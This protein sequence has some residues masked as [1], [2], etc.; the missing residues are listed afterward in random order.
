MKFRILIQLI[1]VLLTILSLSVLFPLFGWIL[2]VANNPEK[3]L[4]FMKQ[5]GITFSMII[6][7]ICSYGGIFLPEI[8][9]EIKKTK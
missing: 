5:I 3:T 2:E 7:L 8:I 4:S 9:Q 1:G 6:L